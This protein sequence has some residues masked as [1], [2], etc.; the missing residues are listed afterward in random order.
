MI[1]LKFIHFSGYCDIFIYEKNSGLD[2]DLYQ[3]NITKS[4]IM[5]AVYR[6]MFKHTI[7]RFLL[8]YVKHE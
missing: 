8:S 1:K 3:L 5:L 2:F 7:E 4:S 6:T